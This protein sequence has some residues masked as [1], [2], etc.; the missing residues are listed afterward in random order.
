M[1][2]L[3][4][5]GGIHG[6]RQQEYGASAME[7][8][9]ETLESKPNGSLKPRMANVQGIGSLAVTGLRGPEAE[10]KPMWMGCP[11]GCPVGRIARGVKSGKLK[12]SKRGVARSWIS[13]N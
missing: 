2:P 13:G 11:S 7:A 12:W 8:I 6:A 9:A 5:I 4:S 3:R 10:R 1:E